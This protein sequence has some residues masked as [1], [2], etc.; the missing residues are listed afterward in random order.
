MIYYNQI[1]SRKNF[2]I[3]DV[4]WK[5]SEKMYYYNIYYK[6]GVFVDQNSDPVEYG[7]GSCIFLHNWDNP[8]EAMAG[9]TAMHPQKMKE[10][11]RWLDIEKHPILIQLTKQSYIS[12]M[13]KWKL[14]DIFSFL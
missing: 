3:S 7:F 6:L 11:V 14:P 5:S 8:N 4:D 10:I 13:E 12:V 1:I 9:C 2:D